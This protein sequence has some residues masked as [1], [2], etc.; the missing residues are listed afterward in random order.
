MI[1]M[2]DSPLGAQ[3]TQSAD[4]TCNLGRYGAYWELEFSMLQINA[5]ACLALVLFLLLLICICS[6]NVSE[7]GTLS[8][9]GVTEWL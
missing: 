1:V 2:Q 4:L 8:I 9:S 6:I 3:K 5:K 7:A